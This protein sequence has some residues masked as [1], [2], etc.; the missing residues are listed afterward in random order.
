MPDKYSAS[1]TTIS[2]LIDI[3]L[4]NLAILAGYLI[5]ANVPTEKN[6]TGVLHFM[7]INFL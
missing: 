7:L 2:K 4:L 1:F 3:M 5:V 6:Y